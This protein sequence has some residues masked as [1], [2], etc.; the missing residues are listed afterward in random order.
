MLE[1]LIWD[2]RNNNNNPTNT[3]VFFFKNLFFLQIPF[4]A[5]LGTPGQPVWLPV[6]V[7]WAGKCSSCPLLI[8]ARTHG[9]AA[10]GLSPSHSLSCS[11]PLSRA[12]VVCLWVSLVEVPPHK[13]KILPL[14]LAVCVC[15]C[16]Y[17]RRFLCFASLCN[18]TYGVHTYTRGNK[19]FACVCVDVLIL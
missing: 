6:L 4:P 2:K 19:A 3:C 13:A 16:T 9:A 1:L 17:I 10:D 12:H 8:F 11:L 18:D 15:V 7:L 14:F 5:V